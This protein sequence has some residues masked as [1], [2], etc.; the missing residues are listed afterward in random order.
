MLRRSAIAVGRVAASAPPAAEAH[1]DGTRNTPERDAEAIAHHYDVSNDLYSL[2]LDAS[3]A[4]S[5][6]YYD[7]RSD[8]SLADAQ[9]AKLDLICRKLALRPDDRLLDLGCGWG[10]LTVHAAINFGAHVTA[11]T[12]STQQAEYVGK[13]V[14]E[15][16]LSDR[17]EVRRQDY[18]DIDDPSFDAIGTIEM[19]EH[20]GERN[21]ASFAAKLHAM[22]Q[23]HGR[24]LVQVMSRRRGDRPGG[25]PFIETYIAPDMHMRP[26][27]DTVALLED[28]GLEVRD[29]HAMREHYVRTIGDWHRQFE[30]RYDD[31]VA[32]V[33]SEMARVWRLYLVGGALAFEQHRMGVDQIL[34]VRPSVDGAS[35][36]ALRRD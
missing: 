6:A 24:L 25:G 11:V 9:Q 12:L 30:R 33:G 1:L 36:M 23:P 17:V 7:D 32:L 3:M 10:S 22:L 19:S 21:F 16:G 8:C 2:F 35:G 26:V 29:V 28:A 18:R 5:C 13:I 4:Y 31:V 15:R 34:S 27:G 14:A 20:V